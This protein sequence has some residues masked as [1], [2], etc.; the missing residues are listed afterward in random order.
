[1]YSRMGVSLGASLGFGSPVVSGSRSIP[2][3]VIAVHTGR[4]AAPKGES[5][6]WERGASPA[7][8]AARA[9]SRLNRIGERAAAA[10]GTGPAMI[11]IAVILLFIVAVGALNAFEFGR[12]D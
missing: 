5:R 7:P 12:V 9:R 3:L 8:V 6:D 11:A 10:R 4:G 2:I 1:M